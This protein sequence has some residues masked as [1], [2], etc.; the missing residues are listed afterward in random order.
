MA[1]LDLNAIIHLGVD[2]SEAE[3]VIARLRAEGAAAAATGG[4]AAGQKAEIVGYATELQRA[5]QM[6]K[7]VNEAGARVGVGTADTVKA[8]YQADLR[9]VN[10]EVKRVIAAAPAAIQEDLTKTVGLTADRQRAL[11]ARDS[12]NQY[13]AG[14]ADLKA[15]GPAVMAARNDN[16]Q[17]QNENKAQAERYRQGRQDPGFVNDLVA[18]DTEAKL[19][20]AAMEEARGGTRAYLEA[21]VKV[22]EE[23]QL[24]AG[25]FAEELA[26]NEN[27]I[28]ATIEATRAKTVL[29][30]TTTLQG[31]GRS[32]KGL[33]EEQLGDQAAEIRRRMGITTG[34]RRTNAVSEEEI[35]D[36]GAKKVA[37]LRLANDTKEAANAEGLLTGEILRSVE[38]QSAISDAMAIMLL[39]LSEQRV[40]ELGGASNAAAYA[41]RRMAADKAAAVTEGQTDEDIAAAGQRQN[42]ELELRNKILQSADAEGR[43]TQL[44]I[45]GMVE[46]KAITDQKAIQTVGYTPARVEELGG[47]AKAADAARA[48]MALD[49]RAT[50]L[51]SQTAESIAQRGNLKTEEARL[52]NDVQEAALAQEAYTAEI[53]RGAALQR[54]KSDLI[55]ISMASLSEEQVARLGTPLAGV[56]AREISTR[57]RAID[58]LAAKTEEDLALD[59]Q[60]YGS[61]RQ[62]QGAVQA[63]SAQAQRERILSGEAGGTRTQKVGG[64]IRGTDPLENQGIGGM[65][66]GGMLQSFKHMVSGFATGALIFGVLS[67]I[68]EASKLQ[69]VLAGVQGQMNALGQGASFS[70][71]R[72]EIKGIA[73][74]TG[75][76]GTEVAN[77]AARLLGVFDDPQRAI[78]ETSAAMK[79]AVVSG[80]DLK[81]MLEE[82]VPVMRAFNVSAEQMGDVA[83]Y[84]HDRFG[85]AEE[86]TLH[87]FGE[88]AS[89]AAEAGFS[90]TQLGIIGAAAANSIGKSMTATGE[91]FS[92][93]IETMMGNQDKI[94]A[95]FQRNP[96]TA[97]LADPI[98]DA[99][100]QG[101]GGDAFQLLLQNYDKLDRVQQD[102]L[103]RTLGSR[104]EWALLNGL[105][106]HSGELMTDLAGAETAQSQAAGSLDK[107][108]QNVASTISRTTNRLKELFQNLVEGL[109]SSG[110][111]AGLNLILSSFEQILKVANILITVFNALNNA[112]K[113]GPF[114]DGLLL[115]LTQMGAMVFVAQKAWQGLTAARAFGGRA[116][117]LLAAAEK[118]LGIT[119]AETAVEEEVATQTINQNTVAKERNMVVSTNMMGETI[120]TPGPMPGPFRRGGAMVAAEDSGQAVA[121]QVLTSNMAGETVIEGGQAI[122]RQVVS[123]ELGA[124]GREAAAGATGAGAMG[125][126]RGGWTKFTGALSSMGSKLAG[127]ATTNIGGE[128]ALATSVAGPVVAMAASGLISTNWA[129]D[130]M[131]EGGGILTGGGPGLNKQEADAKERVSK[132]RTDQ[133]QKLAEDHRGVFDK[134]SDNLNNALFDTDMPID[135]YRKEIN[136]RQGAKGR[137]LVD[138]LSKSGKTADFTTGISNENRKV[139][140][141]RLKQADM[142]DFTKQFGLLDDKGGLDA[143]KLKENLPKIK[144]LSETGDSAASVFLEGLKNVEE[145]QGTFSE[146]RKTLDEANKPHEDQAVKEMGGIDAFLQAQ[147]DAKGALAIGKITPLQ[148]ITEL[149]RQIAGLKRTGPGNDPAKYYQELNAK[150]KERDDAFYTVA[151]Q[152][153]ERMSKAATE[154][155]V[156]DSSAQAL[157]I[158]LDTLP[159]LDPAHQFEM[160]GEVHKATLDAFNEELK[161]I[162]DPAELYKRQ[163]EG[164]A[165]SMQEQSLDMQNQAGS[166]KSASDLIN[167]MAQHSDPG[168]GGAARVRKEIADAAARDGV[169]FTEAARKMYE[170]KIKLFESMGLDP[171]F[172]KAMLAAINAGAFDA[173][174]PQKVIKSDQDDAQKQLIEN[175]LRTTEAGLTLARSQ[176]GAQGRRAQAQLQL[177]S[178]Q[179][180]LNALVAKKDAGI[181]G[182]TI[183]ADIE[184]AQAGVNDALRA[185]SKVTQ[186]VELAMLNWGVV[187]A[188]GDPVKE[189]AARLRVAS[190]QAQLALENAGGDA[191]DPEVIRAQQEVRSTQ[192]QGQELQVNIL[193]SQFAITAAMADSNPLEAARIALQQAQFEEAHAKGAADKN[194]KTAARI[195]AERN[196]SN[197]MVDIVRSQFAVTSALASR[198]P[199]EAAR[200]AMDQAQFELNNA[201]G[202]ADENDKLAAK[203]R[204]DQS[205]ENALSSMYESRA[206]LAQAIANANGDTIG[207]LTIARDE[208][209]RKLT[210]AMA[211]GVKGDALNPF[212]QK[213]VETNDAL[214][215][216]TLQRQQQLIDFQLSMGQITTGTA[217]AS[218]QMMLNQ[219][220]EG[221]D[222]YMAL[223]QKIHGLE[224]QAGDL[225][226]NLPTQL[227]LPTLYESR[228][229]NQ[230]TQAG[231]G[232]QDNRTVTVAINVNG[233]QD[234][235][236][237]AQQVMAAFQSASGSANVYSG[238]YMGVG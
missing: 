114:D 26:A 11:K 97:K 226:F 83:V 149:D 200:I 109:V 78:T 42:A 237:T 160:L 51:E 170:G 57:Q 65:L 238:A 15:N 141:D 102:A 122:E 127:L 147:Y 234:P 93:I 216:G 2:A 146:L 185:S 68:K 4:P 195:R 56:K 140:E 120:M 88:T 161:N 31:A 16:R 85:I 194:E 201:K 55:A 129:R 191:N 139:L 197:A 159:T 223:A 229:L 64:F 136:K 34:I 39:G 24:N 143:G 183:E 225:Q 118:Q 181:G 28:A 41:R 130:Q 131:L 81:T 235:A 98:A 18:V 110:V 144:E 27:Y 204:A 165:V 91:Q 156:R 199:V 138:D 121:G 3:A 214:Q 180:K 50:V 126:L 224:N 100:S 128:G 33:N 213:V 221:T 73:N 155:G 8:S 77:F 108:F 151:K 176:T 12:A 125:V 5:A 30:D 134:M 163:T 169:T 37:D 117:G 178:A 184:E 45:E 17:Q 162:Q 172:E 105:F 187:E 190:R 38:I 231:I 53:V 67:A 219:T 132:M 66:G 21:I 104:K 19:F 63:L 29:R 157:K 208:A 123:K 86:Q 133:L 58:Q 152:R 106:Q 203:I 145:T 76:S 218:L 79:L 142:K 210:E 43:Y 166:I 220:K 75:L 196:Y 35:G 23:V 87:F 137:R 61:K 193:R 107:R 99:F 96:D 179:A 215:K 209:Q 60:L 46:R 95:I 150:I 205:Y 90:L 40:G 22:A 10:A 71:V 92:K 168:E 116:T 13:Q 233:A 232:Y 227:G 36:R 7:Q 124:L 135:I 148:Y 164:V 52:T 171:K 70:N 103:I 222:E 20:R 230:G 48:Q 84:I 175:N 153:V 112:M 177:Q 115:F 158:L 47:T 9:K 89:T 211:Q 173:I 174:D 217:I 49:R 167:Q 206:N 228:R 62:Y 182:P 80:T 25:L 72:D 192:L 189:N 202:A 113:F 154:S 69:E 188:N 54:E 236:A 111:G 1:D 6:R 212:T 101:K 59:A 186:D 44:V 82:M 119:T 14:Q 32:A 198:D 74:E 94:Y 207:S